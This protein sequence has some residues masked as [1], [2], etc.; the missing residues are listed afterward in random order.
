MENHQRTL[1]SQIKKMT[2][3]EDYTHFIF[4]PENIFSSPFGESCLQAAITTFFIFLFEIKYDENIV[5]DGLHTSYRFNLQETIINMLFH[6]LLHFKK[7]LRASQKER[8][9]FQKL[10][11]LFLSTGIS[12]FSKNLSSTSNPDFGKNR[13]S[14]LCH[15][16][17][18][19]FNHI[20]SLE[21]HKE[22]SK[23]LEIL[24]GISEKIQAYSGY[25]YT[26]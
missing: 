11:T 8:L 3:P 14:L 22:S 19:I 17:T 7:H 1:F 10:I 4:T 15:D 24:S 26:L 16:F 23:V 21:T 6:I 18:Q 25:L 20:Q 9:L 5:E 2:L 13:Y 12:D